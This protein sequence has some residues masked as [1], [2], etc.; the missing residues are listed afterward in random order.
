M[1][2]ID[3]IKLSVNELF[4]GV[5]MQRKGIE[6]TGLFDVEV[7]C[8]SDIDINAIISYAALHCGLTKEMIDTYSDYPS[9]EEMANDLSVRNIGFELLR[10]QIFHILKHDVF[11]S[12]AYVD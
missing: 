10:N 5:G 9:R 3:K 11:R 8:T 1:R 6:N 2:T 4:S 12:F 7:K